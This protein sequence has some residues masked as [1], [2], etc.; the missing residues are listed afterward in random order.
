MLLATRFPKSLTMQNSLCITM[1]G[2]LFFLAGCGG[3]SS[4]ASVDIKAAPVENKN[5]SSGQ[6]DKDGKK[7]KGGKLE[8]AT[9]GAG[10][11]WCVE[12]VFDELKGVE[13]VESGYCNGETLNP[14]Y[15]EVCTGQTGHAEVVRIKFDPQVISYEELLEVFWKTHDPT[16][17]NRQGA[18]SGTQYRSGVYYHSE[19]QK[20][21]AAKWK[22]KLDEAGIWNNPIVT[23]IVKAETFY[24]AE[25]Y[26]QNYFELN[27]RQ[28]YCRA[29]IVP[30]MEKFRK[31]FKDKLK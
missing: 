14:T 19:E 1:L 15:Q 22:K 3:I 13:S 10:C 4:T 2:C 21:A 9:F 30:K 27:G 7:R 12:A 31:V 20:A 17:L 18:D 5:E 8:T 6:P 11:F 28:P 16:T 29:V 23:E 24:P 26:H 25:N